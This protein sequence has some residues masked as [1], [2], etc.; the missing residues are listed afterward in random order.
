MSEYLIPRGEHYDSCILRRRYKSAF[1]HPEWEIQCL[2]ICH[3]ADEQNA[4]KIVST[5]IR[6]KQTNSS[7]R[8]CESMANEK[9]PPN[10]ELKCP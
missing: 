8:V 5:P 4:L 10:P 1:L 2:K 6:G 9:S 3:R 7:K